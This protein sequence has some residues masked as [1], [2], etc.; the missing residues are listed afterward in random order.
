MNDGN[1]YILDDSLKS[2]RG[3]YLEYDLAVYRGALNH[4]KKCRVF[5]NIKADA[6]IKSGWNITPAFHYDFETHL[7]SWKHL[8]PVA[9]LLNILTSGFHF[10][11]DLT[12]LKELK[13]VRHND[14]IFAP[15]TRQYG[16]LGFLLWLWLLKEKNRP[17][18]VLL[19]R[20]EYRAF[21]LKMLV[22]ASQALNKRNN[23][24]FATDSELLAEDY[25]RMSGGSKFH[26][27]PIPHTIDLPTREVLKDVASIPIVSLGPPRFEKGIDILAAAI[28]LLEKE[29][30]DK[31]ICFVIQANLPKGDEALRKIVENLIACSNRIP[32]IILIHNALGTPEYYDLAA[33][34]GIIAIPYR[35]H[36]YRS[37]TSG[38]LTEAIAIGKPAIVT[39]Q[40]WMSV[41]LNL[42]GSGVSF[43]DGSIEEF[44]AGIRELVRNFG[45]YQHAAVARRAVWKEKHNEESFSLA[46]LKL[47]E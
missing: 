24:R 14:Y 46:L 28:P 40:T 1:F 19:F 36:A 32:G 38:I 43:R 21:T 31:K 17:R 3:H 41:Q 7:L 23:I 22:S 25:F 4:W 45:K 9:E 13:D 37:R 18:V 15:N 33:S 47:Y 39:D 42:Y 34:A 16:L 10:F 30:R 5:S 26:V 20:Y 8:K 6:A 44:V 29:L 12:R 2:T 27:L 35:S 11:R